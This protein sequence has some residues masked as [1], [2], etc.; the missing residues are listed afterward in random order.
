MAR[1]KQRSRSGWGPAAVGLAL[2]GLMLTP[3]VG[4]AAAAD[5]MQM[6]GDAPARYT[7]EDGDTLWDIA[8]EFLQSPWHWSRL[9]RNNPQIDNP[10]RI[11]PG[12]VLTL[13]RCGGRPCLSRERGRRVVK[14]SPEMRK[15]PRRKAIA[16]LPMSVLQAFL[17]KH[18]LVDDANPPDE[19][20]Y[21][22]AGDNKRLV[23]GAGDRVFA[24]VTE[25]SA[26]AAL[27]PGETLSIL[28]TGEHYHDADGT[29]LGREL[30]GIGEGVTTGRDDDVISLRIN[31]AAR[32]VRND[33]ILLPPEPHLRA[34]NLTPA[35]PQ[36]DVSGHIIGVP[37]G[38]RFI[39]GMQIVAIDLGTEDGIQ[40]GHV[41]SIEPQGESVI[42][43][44][45]QEPVTLPGKAEG[46]LV[47]F[48]PYDRASYA[49]VMA[50]TNTL[51]V[52]DSVHPPR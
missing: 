8:G 20:A 47:V 31:K 50:A 44:R 15:L 17:R 41:L 32:E 25:A 18:R 12:D 40:P 51:A 49:I 29:S 4:T 39:G 5:D 10:Q 42:D 27:A 24:R 46:S 48:R 35:V 52:G 22:I 3:L 30:I 21:V 43:P 36:R 37:G 19:L 14:L 16:P 13:D 9:W 38:V 45:T 34:D 11:Y 2:V 26:S 7:V 28:R 1:H 6:R 33:D 23:S